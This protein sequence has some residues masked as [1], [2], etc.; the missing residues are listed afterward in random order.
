MPGSEYAD[1]GWCTSTTPRGTTWPRSPASTW[2]Y[3]AGR[4]GRAA[5]AVRRGQVDAAEPARRDVPAQRGQD[6]LGDTELSALSER[7]LDELRAT[8]ISIMLQGAA[9][10][11]VPYRDPEQNVAFAQRWTRRRT[12]DLPVP[13]GGAASV[14][15]ADQAHVPLAELS[16]GQLQLAAVAVALAPAAG[17]LLADEPTSQLDHAARDTVLAGHRAAS[18]AELGTTVVLVTHDPAVARRLPRTVTIRDGKIGGEG[19]AGEEY[20]VVTA[21][22][23]LPLPAHAL[24]S[25]CRPARWC[26]SGP[27]GGLLLDVEDGRPGEGDPGRCGRR[28]RASGTAPSSPYTRLDLRRPAGRHAGRDGPVRRRQVVAAVGAGRCDDRR[29]PRWE[30]PLRRRHGLWT[31]RAP[32]APGSSSSRRATGCRVPHGRGERPDAAAGGRGCRP[33]EALQRDQDGAGAAGPGASPRRHLV[34]ELSGGQQQR[35]ALARA[36]RRCS[37][38][39]MLADEPTSDLDGDEP[40]SGSSTALRD[41]AARGA[42]VVMATHDAEAAAET[43][44]TLAL[45]EGVATW[46]REL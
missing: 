22:G 38:R 2:T 44:A 42:S 23:F 31:G 39:C 37:R 41:E 9:R 17:L 13:A 29:P 46:V 21:D 24:P 27:Y 5:R 11:L 1:S 45:D 8:R 28:R 30:V 14:G 34:D 25:G 20:A 4:A 12:T 40:R 18:T 16:A 3:A 26:G 7:E 43:D 35:V 32:R 10:N 36:L 6:L 19:A 15:L 33:R